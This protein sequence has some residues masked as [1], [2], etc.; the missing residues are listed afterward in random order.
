MTPEVD[1]LER[2]HDALPYA[3]RP[4]AMAAPAHIAAVATLF[5]LAPPPP[6]TAR[7]LELGCASGGHLIPLAMRSPEATFVGIDLSPV[8]V[9]AGRRTIAALGLTNI[10]L[11]AAD[12]AA[13]DPV[14]GTFDYIVAHD[15]YSRVSP[16]AQARVLQACHA[17]L[18]P[19]G[20]AFVS[21]N[22][23]PGWKFRE[24]VRDAMRFGSAGI[25]A[26]QERLATARGLVEF[27]A[28]S[29]P[30][31]SVT[32]RV[33]GS[34]VA[35]LAEARPDDVLHEYMESENH[36]VYFNAFV[37]RAAQ[38]G[39]AYVGDARQA[40][41]F[42]SNLPPDVAA[43]VVR[44]SRDDQVK[45]EQL[46]DFITGRMFRQSL[47]A[48]ADAPARARHDL[49]D[50]VLARL[51]FSA[52]IECLDGAVRPDD[53][54]Q[55]FQVMPDKRFQLSNA[56]VKVAAELLCAASP[57][58]LGVDA[59]KA[60]IAERLGPLPP[61]SERALLDFLGFGVRRDLLR[62]RPSPM[63]AVEVAG[64]RPVT[65]PVV[66]HMVALGGAASTLVVANRWHDTIELDDLD[67]ELIPLLD[68]RHDRGQLRDAV[69]AAVA[70]RRMGFS[71]DGRP[72][73]GEPLVRAVEAS[74]DA[75]IESMRRRHLIDA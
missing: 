61:A 42:A 50:A 72:L 48:A 14:L 8:Q 23:Y 9:E 68:G 66:R 17:H 57:G 53:T 15:L 29:A 75:A 7:V 43:V 44:E 21:Y 39:F 3:S 26:P 55:R 5:G 70:A 45:R 31:D 16:E 54:P 37:E 49:P 27:I 34:H 73:T 64:N 19:A 32:G 2:S 46:M 38:A 12:P 58:T 11:H 69:L 13:L 60:G 59:L 40:I 33:M 56:A 74:V 35:E 22:T 63:V 47:L 20:L 10:E 28:R 65:D 30:P 4:V 1:A 41:M 18:S 51:H 24:A 25:E 52:R 36:P 71:R 62:F 67:L 6:A